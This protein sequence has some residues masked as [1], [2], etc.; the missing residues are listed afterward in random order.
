MTWGMGDRRTKTAR[1]DYKKP[2][3]Y[4]LKVSGTGKDACVGQKE[5]TVTVGGEGAA[6][7]KIGATTSTPRCPGGWTLVEESVNG[8]RYTCRARPPPQALKCTN[9]TSYF[10]ERGEMGCR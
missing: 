3:S 6:A 8:S 9:G 7:S 5:V 10:S 1:Y 4:R 2:G